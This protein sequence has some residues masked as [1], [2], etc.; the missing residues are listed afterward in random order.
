[1]V[2]IAQENEPTTMNPICPSLRVLYAYFF[3]K[4]ESSLFSYLI[5]IV[6]FLNGYRDSRKDEYCNYRHY[7]LEHLH[8]IISTWQQMFMLIM[9]AS[10]GFG[11]DIKY[12]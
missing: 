5:V 1:M 9:R 7:L 11:L 2:N 10:N 12:L 8:S 6:S 4:E 3:P